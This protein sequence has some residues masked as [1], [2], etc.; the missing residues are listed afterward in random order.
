MKKYLLFK[1]MAPNL[2]I[3]NERLLYPAISV[4]FPLDADF[5]VER[6]RHNR[7]MANR[8]RRERNRNP[9][10]VSRVSLNQGRN[11]YKSV[12][13][14]YNSIFDHQILFLAKG[15]PKS[16]FKSMLFWLYRRMVSKLTNG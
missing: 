6:T 15:S 10:P 12:M 14:G 9:P 4:R 5:L 7:A 1:K 16:N 2:N 11:C 3:E 8:R 13:R